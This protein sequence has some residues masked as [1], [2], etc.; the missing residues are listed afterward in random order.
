M[1]EV[2]DEDWANAWKEFYHPVRIGRR[3]IVRPLWREV[4]PDSARVQLNLDPG[5]AFGTG[6]HPTTQLCLEALDSDI[7]RHLEN[8]G[9]L[10]TV[11]AGRDVLDLGAG[12]GILGIAAVK[13]GAKSLLA[14][15]IDSVAVD[16]AIG[17]FV[18]ND[19][20]LSEASTPDNIHLGQGSLPLDKY[21]YSQPGEKTR[22]FDLIFANIIARVIIDL[23]PDLER[24]LR[25]DGL[26]IASGIIKERREEVESA[27]V[28]RGLSVEA[29]PRGDWFALICKKAR[30]K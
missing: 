18:S 10:N 3:F 13:L 8:G 28:A 5:M 24:S 19:I 7:D 6:L 22:D 9:A 14:L 11:L 30:P 25:P 17:N 21:G 26:L 1:K 2:A 27:L 15:D 4:A 20:S 29:R 12:S 23:A 16:A